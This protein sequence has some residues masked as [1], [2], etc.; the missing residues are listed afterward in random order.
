VDAE[1]VK[2]VVVRVRIPPAQGHGGQNFTITE[3]ALDD[4]K[5]TATSRARFFSPKE[6][7]DEK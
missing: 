4:P 5:L 2:S 1:D 3:Q 6:H 7:H